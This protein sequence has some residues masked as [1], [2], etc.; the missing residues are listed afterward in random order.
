MRVPTSAIY[1]RVGIDLQ[2]ALAALVRQ[3]TLLSSGRRILSPSDDPGG[4][5]RAL[6]VRSRQGEGEQFRRNIAEARSLLGSADSALQS[7]LEAIT[8]AREV[9]I[10]GA[11][12]T[13]DALARR[14]LASQVDALVETLVSLA[15]SRA[16]SGEYLFGGQESTTAPF[17]VT[18]DPAGRIVQVTPSARGIDRATLAEVATG[19]TIATGISGTAVFGPATDPTYAF[20]VLI[21]LRD[22]LDGTRILALEPDVGASGAINAARYLGIDA[23]ADLQIGGPGGSAPIGL[24]LATDDTVSHSGNATSAIATAVRINAET[25]VTGVSATVTPARITYSAGSFAA[26]LVLDGSA[27]AQ[28]VIN[29]QAITGSIAGSTPGER[30]DALVALI[31]AS[32]ATTGVRAEAVPGT[33]DFVLIADDGRNISIETDGTVTSSSVNALVF[34]FATGLTGTGAATAVVARGEVRLT[35]AGPIATIIAPGG[36]FADQVTGEGTTGIQAA[37]PQLSAMLDRGT[38][39]LTTTGNRLRWVQLLDERLAS[40]AV[41]LASTLSRTED[42]DFVAAIIEFRQM[43][44]AYERSLASGAQVLQT[45]LLDFLR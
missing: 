34:G 36:D 41:D 5:A 14:S 4:A 19:V 33:D 11:N 13:N 3:Q 6:A 45:S 26:D 44:L 21:R 32:A 28:L 27:G 39:A 31:N 10:Q 43:Q 17:T 18:R 2:A 30:R 12:D 29:G 23:V 7:V 16:T 35:A 25:A 38:A 20:D 37:L 8:Q 1:S 24:T 9:A 22:N 15:N 42:L 40:D